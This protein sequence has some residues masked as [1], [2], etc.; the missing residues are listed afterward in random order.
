MITMNL[1]ERDKHPLDLVGCYCEIFWSPSN[2]MS[3]R[4]CEKCVYIVRGLANDMVCVE[5]IYDAIEGEHGKDQIYWVP[6]TAIQYM[7]VMTESK[8]KNRIDI[9]EREVFEEMPRD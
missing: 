8:V 3:R 4:Q 1:S 6:S 2:R 9:L 7:H 5:L